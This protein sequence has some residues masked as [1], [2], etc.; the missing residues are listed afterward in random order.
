[1]EK[2]ET[3]I[4]SPPIL[5]YSSG[6]SSFKTVRRLLFFSVFILIL[7]AVV[8]FVCEWEAETYGRM[9]HLYF[10]ES[11]YGVLPT[12]RHQVS[13]GNFCFAMLVIS[14][15][16]LVYVSC[17]LRFREQNIP[18]KLWIVI[19][20]IIPFLLQLL[21]IPAYAIVIYE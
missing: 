15:A 5:A 21:I 13:G 16:N 1:M 8:I 19:L 18:C 2:Q 7:Q 3:S 9:V 14:L 4:S 12:I 17:S 11:R 10:V 6:T 20:A